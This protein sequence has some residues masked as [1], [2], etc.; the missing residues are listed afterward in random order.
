MKTIVKNLVLMKQLYLNSYNE[1]F[2]E[3]ISCIGHFDAI[4][5]IEPKDTDEKKNLYLTKGNKNLSNL[6]NMIA[7]VDEELIGKYSAMSI[8]LF[9]Y[10]QNEEEEK[11]E[12]LFWQDIYDVRECYSSVEKYEKCSN[13]E[14][15]EELIKR[16]LGDRKKLDYPF[17]CICLL[18]TTNLL[19]INNLIVQINSIENFFNKSVKIITYNTYDHADLITIIKGQCLLSIRRAIYYIENLSKILYVDTILG[20]VISPSIDNNSFL[21]TPQ[22][23]NKEEKIGDLT[24]NISSGSD[25]KTEM[26]YKN[27]KDEDENKKR[28]YSLGVDNNNFEIFGITNEMFYQILNENL[29]HNKYEPLIFTAQTNINFYAASITNF[30]KN[31]NLLNIETNTAEKN[32]FIKKFLNSIDNEHNWCFKI[33]NKIK[34]KLKHIKSNDVTHTRYI[35]FLKIINTLSQYEANI[36]GSDLFDLI[37]PVISYYCEQFLLKK[38]NN[39]SLI[40]KEDVANLF[41]TFDDTFNRIIHTEHKFMMIPGYNGMLFDIP[42]KLYLLYL[43]FM[44]KTAEILSAKDCLSEDKKLPPHRILLIPSMEDTPTTFVDECKRKEI[45]KVIFVNIPQKHL[46]QPRSLCIILAHELAHYVGNN[47]RLRENRLECVIKIIL[48]ILYDKIFISYKDSSVSKKTYIAN[49]LTI[50]LDIIKDIYDDD[51]NITDEEKVITAFNKYLSSFDAIYSSHNNIS[52]TNCKFDDV[53]RNMPFFLNFIYENTIEIYSNLREILADLCAIILLENSFLDYIEAYRVSCGTDINLIN[54]PDIDRIAVVINILTENCTIYKEEW[55]KLSYGNF[56]EI[57]KGYLNNNIKN[58]KEIFENIKCYISDRKTKKTTLPRSSSYSK[59]IDIASYQSTWDIENLY[60]TN[61]YEE[62][63]S[64]IFIYKIHKSNLYE[65]RNIYNFFRT[66]E[67]GK[68]NYNEKLELINQF[69]YDYK[70]I[71]KKIK[72]DDLNVYSDN[73]NF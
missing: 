33:I 2:R 15:K 38:E 19:E 27:F 12:A 23:I 59:N 49:G 73:Q 26:F 31:N 66:N 58:L 48:N 55:E 40:L 65:I 57:F 46:Y 45:K 32:Y 3:D 35:A 11:K 61:C 52:L 17:Y 54:Y 60:A 42:I 18:K 47:L 34:N 39:E 63:L 62:I 22:I 29:E 70:K 5:I 20:A 64:T 51:D 56:S 25:E 37:L 7:K 10:V 71:A 43:S 28:T 50:I 6:W 21:L 36:I 1:T 41:T 44:Y 30:W 4:K 13:P 69:I 24:I 14:E 9:K 67:L 68:D 53:N 8:G 72:E 16:L